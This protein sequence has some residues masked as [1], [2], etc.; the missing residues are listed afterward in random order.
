MVAPRLSAH[1]VLA[2]TASE[3]RNLLGNERLSQV[4]SDEDRGKDAREERV[5]HRTEMH[6]GNESANDLIASH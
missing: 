2:L 5:R 1:F 6:Q 4:G 3:G